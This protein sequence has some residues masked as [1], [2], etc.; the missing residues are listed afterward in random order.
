MVCGILH[1]ITYVGIIHSV[2]QCCIYT[3]PNIFS[4][5]LPFHLDNTRERSEWKFIKESRISEQLP[6]TLGCLD[7]ALRYGLPFIHSFHFVCTWGNMGTQGIGVY[8]IICAPR[9][10]CTDPTQQTG[11]HFKDPE[12][13]GITSPRSMLSA[14]D[15]RDWYRDAHPPPAGRQCDTHTTT[16]TYPYTGDTGDFKPF[17]KRSW[18]SVCA[19]RH[20]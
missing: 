16:C 15:S 5:T 13:P 1:N 6:S 4:S 18:I 20:T 2:T 3:V 10:E 11:L 9:Q 17:P 8:T 12:S 7:I 19:R 14:A